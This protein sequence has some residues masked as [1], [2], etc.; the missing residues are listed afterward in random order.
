V[1]DVRSVHGDLG[2]VHHGITWTVSRAVCFGQISVLSI[3]SKDVDV[4]RCV[5][6]RV[7]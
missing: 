4:L 7:F 1:S 2:C 5:T 6:P 3:P